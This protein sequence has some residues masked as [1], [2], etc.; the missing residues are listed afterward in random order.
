VTG[1][2]MPARI[3]FLS[4]AFV[5]IWALFW[6]QVSELMKDLQQKLIK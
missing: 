3:S 1:F 4:A 5:W 2:L 6:M